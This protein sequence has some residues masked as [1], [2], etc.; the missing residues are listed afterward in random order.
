MLSVVYQGH[1]SCSVSLRLYVFCLLVVLVK[2]SVIAK[3]LV[4]KISSE[5]AYLW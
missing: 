5:E 4:R 1:F 2:L 3:S